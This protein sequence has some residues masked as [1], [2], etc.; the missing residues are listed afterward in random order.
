MAVEVGLTFALRNPDRWQVPWTQLYAEFMELAELADELGYDSI[1]TSEHHFS[2]DGYCPSPLLMSSAIAVRTRRIRIGQNVLLLPLHHP[3]RLA[4]DCAVIDIMSGGRLILG[5]GAGFRRVEFESFGI[6]LDDRPARMEE[7]IALLRAAWSGKTIA[8]HG[9]L[10]DIDG[11]EV[12]PPPVQPSGPPIWMGA[13]SEPATRRA[14]RIA[15][16]LLV[17]RGR[18]QVHWFRDAAA[19]AGRDPDALTLASIRIV[20]IAESPQQAMNEVGE[21]L[22]YHEQ[23]YQDWFRHEGLAHEKNATPFRSATDLP[24]ERYLF[25]DPDQI[26]AQ[27]LELRETYDFSHLLLWPRMPGVPVEVARRTIEL[28]AA[29]VL[30]ALH[31]PPTT[32]GPN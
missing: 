11:I 29:H 20:H 26:L 22:L 3:L 32:C 25:G 13:R 18:S 21:Q 15:D 6:A 31:G 1:W 8:H 5:V 27:I 14:G 10:Y 19:D 30:P 12:T 17:S 23:R 2:D 7:G 9:R 16:G 24:L 4:E 28:F